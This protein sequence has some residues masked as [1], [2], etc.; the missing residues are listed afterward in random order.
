MITSLSQYEE[1]VPT[2]W[3]CA[4]AGVVYLGKTKDYYWQ[5][6]WYN[7][8]TKEFY[9]WSKIGEQ[10]EGTVFSLD[11]VQECNREEGAASFWQ[12]ILY[13]LA[14]ALREE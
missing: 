5:E 1:E 13:R 10:L 9:C 4:L 8:N 14:K 2:L 3:Y 7:K 11:L 6:I 12:L